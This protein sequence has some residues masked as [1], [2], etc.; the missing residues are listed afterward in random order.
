MFKIKPKK[1]HRILVGVDD[2]PDARAAFS[3]AVDK[4]KRDGS[5][6][7]IVSI[8]ETNGVNVYQILDRDF[9]H[10]SRDEM[11]KRIDQYVQAAIDYGI[12]PKKITAIVDQ[13]ERPAERI[14]N[15]VIP[16]F[17]PDLLI[18]GS[19]GK[20]GSRKTVGSQASYMVKHSGTSVFVIQT[21]DEN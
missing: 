16:E 11:E 21:T 20:P 13:G 17:E 2:A 9:T 18:I 6:L 8:Y 5:E 15:H 3:Y 7:G 4:A 19:I 1:F 14:C 10:S 12:D